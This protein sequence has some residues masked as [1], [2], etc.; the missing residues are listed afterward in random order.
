MS[1]QS[2][3]D[4]LLQQ[5]KRYIDEGRFE[6]AA[7][8]Y[9]KIVVLDPKDYRVQLRLAELQ[10]RL[11]QIGDAVTLY[12]AVAEAYVEEGFYLKA[13]TVYKNL[14]RLNPSLHD[15][16]LALAE[17]Y[18]KMG[19]TRDAIHQYQIL[20]RNYEQRGMNTEA[21]D[22]RKRIV[23]LDPENVAN[24]V[25]LAESFQL[26][27]EDEASVQEYEA[28]AE[29]LQASADE[30]RLIELYEKI[31][32]RRPDRLEFLRRLCQIHGR[33][34]EFR[35]VLDWLVKCA[36]AIKE[37]PELLQLQATV[38][39]RLNQMESARNTWH[40]VAELQAGRG[41]VEAAIVAYEE[42]LVLGVEDEATL[43]EEVETLRA[44]AWAEM[45][46]SAE[47]RRRQLA[48]EEAERQ[49]METAQA[50][51]ADHIR[52]QEEKARQR[53][54]RRVPGLE[55]VAAPIRPFSAEEREAMR[56]RALA[57]VQLGEVYDRMGMPEEA[58]IE[59][60]KALQ[61]WRQ[62]V[63]AGAGDAGIVKEIA[64]LEQRMAGNAPSALPET[65]GDP[66]ADAHAVGAATTSPIPL[67]V[68]PAT[69]SAAVPGPS[70]TSPL[71]PARPPAA[72]KPSKK[73]IS[74]V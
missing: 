37:D 2:S 22:L 64:R 45:V 55:P 3:K 9:Q 52:G 63:A 51:A 14:L 6:K 30:S 28:L 50:A 33:R 61:A 67:S 24:R 12:W 49:A 58:G 35:A 4:D 54:S 5:A 65:G 41:E 31:L 48:T 59:Y 36:A 70:V 18:E 29:Q 60:D 32:N 16:N 26:H 44:G 11:K 53:A 40:Q 21:L 17:L 10:V 57:G 42:M 1:E 71:S 46:E 74:Y 69:V 39:A 15:A 68:A 20:L 38:M 56:H 13:V 7:Q 19:L 66:L 72:K 27:G 25:R 43:R 73:R 34:Q 47:I 62:L 23:A 8:E